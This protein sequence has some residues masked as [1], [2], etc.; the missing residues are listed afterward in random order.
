[1]TVKDILN[2][3]S[4]K[5]GVYN[6]NQIPLDKWV[7]YQKSHVKEHINFKE[8]IDFEYFYA[9]LNKIFTSRVNRPTASKILNNAYF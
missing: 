4:K 5:E 6:Y 7:A 2:E 8:D 9:F 1:M 3:I